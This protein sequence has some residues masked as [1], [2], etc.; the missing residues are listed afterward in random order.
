MMHFLG[1]SQ[2]GGYMVAVQIV[3]GMALVAD[4]VNKA[5][6]PWLF[7]RLSDSN[8]RTKRQIVRMTYAYFG[9]VLA[10]ALALAVAL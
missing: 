3:F 7:D 2:T 5:Y 8:I 6:V 10:L 4:A 9:A 1:L